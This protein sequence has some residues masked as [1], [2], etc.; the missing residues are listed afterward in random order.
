MTMKREAGRTWDL[1]VL[2]EADKP[3]RLEVLLNQD[4]EVTAGGALVIREHRTGEIARAWAAGR[5]L[6]VSREFLT[7][8]R[9]EDD[10]DPGNHPH[11]RK[12]EQ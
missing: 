10:E 9:H 7:T 6:E 4:P 12:V 3:V 2:D 5:W 11:G 8:G 1:V